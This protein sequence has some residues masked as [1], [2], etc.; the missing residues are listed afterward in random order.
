MFTCHIP[1]LN[2]LKVMTSGGLGTMGFALPAAIGAK[3]GMPNRE[4]FAM[5]WWF[6]NDHSGIRNNFSD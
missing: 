5:W 2:N 3:M 6:S 1:N 4:W